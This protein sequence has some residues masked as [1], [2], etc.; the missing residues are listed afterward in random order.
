MR[1]RG[2]FGR[3]DLRAIPSLPRRLA[4]CAQGASGIELALLAPVLIFAVLMMVEVGLEIA[5][6]MELG[7]G[8]RAGA[9]AA[10][11]RSDDAAQIG[12]IVRVAA[13]SPAEMTVEVARGCAC[14]EAAAACNV[15]CASGNAPSVF[16]AID[17]RLPY[18][19]PLRG[20]QVL[21][22]ATRVQIR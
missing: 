21:E 12:E 15:P 4:G 5:A 8:V 14:G 22:A 2:D 1:R 10:L 18:A 19:A 9:Q 16:V 7:R 3:A 13:G 17:A 6:R 20:P 11:N